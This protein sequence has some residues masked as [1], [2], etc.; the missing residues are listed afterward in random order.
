MKTK[1][2]KK[3]TWS[4]R[5]VDELPSE[6][7]EGVKITRVLDGTAFDNLGCEYVLLDKGQHLEPHVHEEANSFILILR[8]HGFVQVEDREIP[9]GQGHLVYVPAGVL[10]GFRTT[11]EPIVMYGFQS[12]PIIKSKE[13]VDIVFE[14]TGNQGKL[15]SS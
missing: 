8:G 12:P 3:T 11:D 1:T 4:V 9:I 13:N 5:H 6:R 7:L 10:H 15:V 2:L 14:K